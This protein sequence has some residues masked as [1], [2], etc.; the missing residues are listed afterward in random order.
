MSAE[1]FRTM[2]PDILASPVGLMQQA[3]RTE[4]AAAGLHVDLKPGV[5]VAVMK[6]K[7]LTNFTSSTEVFAMNQHF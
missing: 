2:K 4:M 1:V 5:N 3:S 7:I 6:L